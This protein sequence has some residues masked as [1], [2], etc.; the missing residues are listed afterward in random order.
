MADFKGKIAVTGLREL[1]A[2]LELI[3]AD[4]GPKSVNYAMR[5]TLK[6]AM[7]EIIEPAVRAALPIAKGAY[8]R[9]VA[10]GDWE[11]SPGAKGTYELTDP[12]WLESQIVVRARR[13]SRT[14]IGF[15]VGFKDE[16]FEGP[17]FFAGM[18]E[19]GTKSRERKSGGRTGQ[20]APDSFLRVP[21]YSNASQVVAMARTRLA[22]WIAER[23]RA[24]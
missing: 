6:A 17:T 19:Y 21:L 9:K 18:L 1:D 7:K 15:T 11:K 12:G 24:A 22:A 13:R 4:D 3:A 2:Q 5:N 20:V 10:E 8:W 23:N 16:L 14:S